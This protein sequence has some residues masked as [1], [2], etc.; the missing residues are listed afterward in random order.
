MS[1]QT[2]PL[3]QAI[4]ISGK[5]PEVV[6]YGYAVYRL[7]L[8]YEGVYVERDLL[9]L[10]WESKKGEKKIRPIR[11]VSKNYYLL[12]HSRLEQEAKDAGFEVQVV[13]T[14]T[15]FKAIAYRDEES[16]IIIRNS[17]R[18]GSFKIDLSVKVEDTYLPVFSDFIRM[19]HL[20]TRG[21]VL[22]AT[23]L[24][25]MWLFAQIIPSKLSKLKD[26]IVPLGFLDF[27]KGLRVVKREYE[28]GIL[29]KE[30]IDEIGAQLYA[31]LKRYTNLY[32]FSVNL[33]REISTLPNTYS[34]R[35]I[36]DRIERYTGAVIRE[37]LKLR[38]ALARHQLVSV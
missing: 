5:K 9:A 29:K 13:E 14:G 37:V 25:E 23:A 11:V 24:E 30:E 6:E 7:P 38:E 28:N 15:A 36:K 19:P 16:Q 33:M 34:Y 12:P 31:K 8:T 22:N 1:K 21:E 3:I 2:H 17:Y 27:L 4:N 10:S 18:V 32:D 20:Q 26:E 35:R